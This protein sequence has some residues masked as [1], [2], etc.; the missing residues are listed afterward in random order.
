MNNIQDFLLRIEHLFTF[1][2]IP[3]DVCLHITNDYC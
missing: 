2:I 3:L 1:F